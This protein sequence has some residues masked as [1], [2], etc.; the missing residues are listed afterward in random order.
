LKFIDLESIEDLETLPE[1]RL[2]NLTS[3]ESLRI[4]RCNRLNSLSPSIQH[5]V[6]LQDLF[7]DDCP[8]L[9]LANVEDGMQWQGL[10]SLLSNLKISYLPKLVSFPLGL[11]HAT[12]LQMLWIS[13]CKNLTAIPEWIHNCTSL[14]EL[15]I[16]GCSSLTS[17]PEGIR[18]LTSLQ[19]LKIKNC[20]ILLQRCKREVGEDWGKIAHIPNL[21]LLYEDSGIDSS[22]YLNPSW[23]FK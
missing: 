21:Q 19:G 20:P 16:D 10:K 8:E 2:N 3:L 11:Q 6:A 13:N 15:A 7:L 18:S 12:T 4:R 1:E 23:K 22:F 17:L 14:R 9:E 5:L